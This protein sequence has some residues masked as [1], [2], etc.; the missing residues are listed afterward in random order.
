M[1]KWYKNVFVD[2]TVPFQF[3]YIQIWT[4]LS[5]RDYMGF[6]PEILA[7]YV[8]LHTLW[9]TE[10]TYRLWKPVDTRLDMC[11]ANVHLFSNLPAF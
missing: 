5:N 7:S 11:D 10:Q 6:E 1:Q 9:G 3:P 2:A 4:V 8:H